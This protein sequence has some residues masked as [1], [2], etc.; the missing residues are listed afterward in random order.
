MQVC[1]LKTSSEY[2]RHHRQVVD[3]QLEQPL[4]YYST[5]VAAKQKK[6]KT[7]NDTWREHSTFSG[8][9][10]GYH[11]WIPQYHRFLAMGYKSKLIEPA[12]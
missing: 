5:W 2:D 9:V 6:H 4:H 11:T 8:T 7:T 12:A 10:M 1:D 3:P